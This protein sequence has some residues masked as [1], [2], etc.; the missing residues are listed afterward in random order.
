MLKGL[1]HG[2]AAGAAGTTA[3]NGATYVDMAVRGRPTSS[4]PE[5]TVEKIAG[6]VGVE[7]P[8][9]GDE[10]QNRLQGL[11]PLSGIAVG[12]GVGAV[13]GILRGLHLRLPFLADSV[14]IGA[15]AMVAA[16]LPMAQLGITDPK[17]WSQKDW[18]ADA[19]PHLAYG[20]ITH[21]TLRAMEK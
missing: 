6:E 5:K 1:F 21:L 18:L 8:G 14:L 19:V 10:R 3:L 4:T 20:A 15:A 9:Q 2:L 12:V 11:G 16:D 17:T 7:I 13:F